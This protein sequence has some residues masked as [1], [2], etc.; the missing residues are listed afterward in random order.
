MLNP[1]PD[2]AVNTN[3]NSVPS[4]VINPSSY[5]NSDNKML[6]S[7]TRSGLNGYTPPLPVH[8]PTSSTI[9]DDATCVAARCRPIK[10]CYKRK[11]LYTAGIHQRNRKAARLSSVCCHCHPPALSCALCSGRHNHMK[12][13]DPCSMSFQER[14]SL[15]SPTY[16]PVLSVP[17]G[18]YRLFYC[19]ALLQ[20]VAIRNRY[21]SPS[22]PP[23][24]CIFFS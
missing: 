17:Q 1:V 5:G 6:T 21:S 16:H 7:G 22:P 8:E 23:S 20:I 19:L 10:T 11:L 4:Y 18:M 15:L 9:E 2:P 14:M 3:G 24:P 12:T 13:V